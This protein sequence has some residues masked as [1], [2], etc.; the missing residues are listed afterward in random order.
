MGRGR[1]IR[2][3]DAVLFLFVFDAMEISTLAGRAAASGWPAS[4]R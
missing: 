4:G 2:Q 1:R 3:T